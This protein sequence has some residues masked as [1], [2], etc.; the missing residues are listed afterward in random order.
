MSAPL[1]L[2]HDWIPTLERF[3]Q[4]EPLVAR[5]VVTEARG[6]TPREP[7]AFMLVGHNEVEGSIGGGRLEWEAIAAARELLADSAAL[8]RVNRVVLAADVGQCCGGVVS[9]WLERFTRDELPV[10]R[11]ASEAGARG[12]T[13]LVS[14]VTVDGMRRRVVRRQDARGAPSAPAA[15]G[16]NGP[17]ASIGASGPGGAGVSASVSGASDAVVS[18]SVS[19]A[20][21]AVVSASVFGAS[22]AVVSASVSGA[23]DAV[24]SVAASGPSDAVVTSAAAPPLH[25]AAASTTDSATASTDVPPAISHLLREPRHTARPV[26]VTNPAGELIFIERLDD[27]LPAVWLY[28]AGHVGQALARIL[29]DLPLRLTWIDSRAELFPNTLPDGVRILRDADSVATISEAPVGAYFVVMSH[30]HPLDYELCHALL[31]RNDFAWLG[32]IGSESKA[33][34]FR[35]RLARTGLGSEVI[36]K[37]VCPIGVEGIT[38]KWPAAIAV[39]VA[40]QLMQKMSVAAE[41]PELP[42]AVAGEGLP[43]A[44][45]VI[46]RRSFDVP[47]PGAASPSQGLAAD[48]RASATA[49]RGGSAAPASLASPCAPELCATCGSSVTAPADPAL[50]PKPGHE[51]VTS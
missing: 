48:P 33:A 26:V 10:L 17:V 32:L 30:S 37:L 43:Q 20:S 29:A 25:G 49:S 19:E 41:Q 23:S 28:G 11:A 38:S 15:S 22:D 3:L 35:S 50:T 42:S 45:S 2:P 36:A 27:D 6:S 51:T 7:G 31:E 14:E 44:A 18:A 4:R 24:V 9:V 47:T 16:A 13:V 46:Q 21:D 8:A 12:P 40:A 34:R 1:S 5:V 39:A